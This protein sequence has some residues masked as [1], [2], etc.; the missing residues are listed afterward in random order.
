M[1]FHRP[2]NKVQWHSKEEDYFLLWA[3]VEYLTVW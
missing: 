1:H 2:V 3:E